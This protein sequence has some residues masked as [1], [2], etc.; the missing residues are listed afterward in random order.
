M[1]FDDITTGASQDIKEATKAARAMVTQYGFSDAVGLINYA[2]DSDE[3][4]IG[5][6][7]AHSKPYGENTARLIDEEVKRI[8]DSCHEKARQM[9][10]E[11][12][13]VL[14]ASAALLMEREK[15]SREE[16]EALFDAPAAAET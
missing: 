13:D 16:F 5:R 15:I 8:I 10:G 11:H 9:I 7:L 4:F 12:M 3:V 2:D 14:H 6:D 1:I